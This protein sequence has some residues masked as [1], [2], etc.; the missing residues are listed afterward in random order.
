MENQELKFKTTLQSA[1]IKT[2]PNNSNETSIYIPKH[3]AKS[4]NFQKNQSLT[5]VIEKVNILKALNKAQAFLETSIVKSFYS[6]LSDV[7]KKAETIFDDNNRINYTVTVVNNQNRWYFKDLKKNIINIRDFLIENQSFLL[8]SL[9]N[10]NIILQILNDDIDNASFDDKAF[11]D[12]NKKLDSLNET[13]KETIVY[14]RLEQSYLRKHLFQFKTIAQCCICNRD[15][16]KDF[17][18][19]AHL[20]MRSKCTFEE[21]MDY[22]VIV[23][24]M[25]SFGC[26]DLYER[27]YI[28]VVNGKIIKLNKNKL[29]TDAVTEYI[30]IIEGKSFRGY[31]DLNKKYL[32]WH[33]NYHK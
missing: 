22:K 18:V 27:G 19:T 7:I 10:D 26:D 9:E 14:R 13:D 3:I 33:Y 16:P 17:L 24:S 15:F 28:S 8:F 11:I 32:E 23:A 5:L 12:S 2:S 31:N 21:K 29:V 6:D 4:L 30:N 1:G 25:C 20:K